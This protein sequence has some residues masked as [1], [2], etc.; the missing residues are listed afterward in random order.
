M[1]FLRVS[2]LACFLMGFGVIVLGYSRPAFADD[3]TCCNCTCGT[4]SQG[5][6]R[7]RAGPCLTTGTGQTGCVKCTCK[8]VPGDDYYTCNPING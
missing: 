7:G 6:D 2:S 1:R 3:G 4:D 5:S 8:Y